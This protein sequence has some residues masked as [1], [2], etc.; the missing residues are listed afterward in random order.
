MD[1]ELQRARLLGGGVVGAL[2]VEQMVALLKIG[3][4]LN[5]QR[6]DLLRH[7]D[8]ALPEVLKAAQGHIAKLDA[9]ITASAFLQ[10]TYTF[11]AARVDPEPSVSKE[12]AAM[13]RTE[14]FIQ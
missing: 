8:A 9:A 12:E 5:E 10:R 13:A 11:D 1:G 3:V 4:R 7:T 14:D 2:H 6:D